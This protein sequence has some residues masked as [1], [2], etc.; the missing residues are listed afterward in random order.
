MVFSS[1]LGDDSESHYRVILVVFYT[2]SKWISGN[3]Y[4]SPLHK[5]TTVIEEISVE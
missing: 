4:A 3:Q 2:E 5:R 1:K